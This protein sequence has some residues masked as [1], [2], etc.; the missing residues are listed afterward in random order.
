[1]KTNNSKTITKKAKAKSP[2][3]FT[4]VK[5][6]LRQAQSTAY[7]TVNSVMV[8]V[9]WHVGRLIVEDEQQGKRKAEYGKAILQD[10]SNRL[11]KEF[12]SGYSVQSLWNM[13][14]F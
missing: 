10:L 2:V 14:Q 7:K 6:I 4:S 1:M 12:K 13:R 8:V 9:Y 11:N 5:D 3:L